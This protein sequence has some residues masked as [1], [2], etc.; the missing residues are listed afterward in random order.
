MAYIDVFSECEFHQTNCE[1]SFNSSVL[2][3]A[4]I[5]ASKLFYYYLI[6]TTL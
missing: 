6:M 1:Y 2:F 4:V 5:L 3:P